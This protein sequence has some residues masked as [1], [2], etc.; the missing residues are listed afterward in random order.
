MKHKE[1]TFCINCGG[2]SHC[3]K[4]LIRKEIEIINNKIVNEIILEECKKCEC[5][6]CMT[7]E[8]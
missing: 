5:E 4:K 8:D 3:G 2:S 1:K 6:E 7:N